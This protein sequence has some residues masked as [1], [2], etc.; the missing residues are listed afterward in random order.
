[1]T[2]DA[3]GTA[4]A[5]PDSLG[6]RRVNLRGGRA[7]GDECG[8][9]GRERSV[10]AEV[11]AAAG[12]AGAGGVWRNEDDKKRKRDNEIRKYKKTRRTKLNAEATLR[13]QI[14]ETVPGA[15]ERKRPGVATAQADRCGRKLDAIE[16]NAAGIAADLRGELRAE[17]GGGGHAVAGKSRAE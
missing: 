2:E 7:A 4:A 1:S 10:C 9:A 16:G 12:V 5:V 8:R 15:G 17:P 3:T 11:G 13:Q 14:E 6:P